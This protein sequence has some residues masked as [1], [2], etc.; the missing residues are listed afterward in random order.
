[1]ISSVNTLKIFDLINLNVK[2]I[3]SL[4][5]TLLGKEGKI[6]DETK[7]MLLLDVNNSLISV[8]KNIISLKLNVDDVDYVV[9]GSKLLQSPSNRNT[10]LELS[11]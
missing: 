6:L 5:S 10:K 7:N 9:Q 2:I 11:L 3:S 1:M 8:P 4:D